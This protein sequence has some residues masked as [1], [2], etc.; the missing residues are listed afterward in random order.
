MSFYKL[1]LKVDPAPLKLALK[2]K[3]YLY[4]KYDLRSRRDSP[5]R[6]MTDIWVRTNDV[7]PY[8]MAGDMTGFTDK[9]DPVWY[10]VYSELPEITA[11]VSRLMSYMK[12]ESLGTI[13]ITKLPSGGKIYPHVDSGWNAEY[14]DKFYVPIENYEGSTFNFNGEHINPTEG[15]VYQFDNSKL[16]WIN[17]DSLG[18]RVAMIICI[19]H[20]AQPRYKE[21]S[22]QYQ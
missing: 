5:H 8:L 1:G 18:D 7:N 4:G 12:G 16:H 22:C 10:P 20:K 2:E 11:I 19:R 14:F 9:H 17:N 21:E 6:E 3:P 15:E 13:L